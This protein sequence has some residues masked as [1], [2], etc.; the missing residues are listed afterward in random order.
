MKYKAGIFK[1]KTAKNPL[2]VEPWDV[3]HREGVRRLSPKKA[4][5][6]NQEVSNLL[7]L[8]MI[9]PSLSPRACGTVLVKNKNGELRFCCNFTPTQ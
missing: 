4:E 3:P 1:C 6:A 8:G 2:E 9:Q 5:R 7:A